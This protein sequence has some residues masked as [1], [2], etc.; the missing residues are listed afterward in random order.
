MII[1]KYITA[2]RHIEVQIISDTHG[3]HL[4]LYE[5]D[6]S[7]QRRYQKVIEE[8]PAPEYAEAVREA[9]TKAAQKPHNL[10]IMLGL[11]RSNLSRMARTACVKM[12]FGSW[13]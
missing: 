4:H 7:L 1:E 12:A 5:R 2:P 8:A 3:H 9:M 6:C 11:E 13:K 10:L